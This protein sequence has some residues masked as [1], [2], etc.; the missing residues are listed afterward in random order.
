[1]SIS[2]NRLFSGEEML[3]KEKLTYYP[4]ETLSEYHLMHMENL[5]APLSIKIDPYFKIHKKKFYFIETLKK[6]K[7]LERMIIKWF[8]FHI[9]QILR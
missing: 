1:M 8:E 5:K 4:I 3:M 7:R 9:K 2:G 6:F